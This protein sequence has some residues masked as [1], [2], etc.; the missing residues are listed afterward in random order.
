MLITIINADTLI[1]REF[2]NNTGSAAAVIGTLRF[3]SGALA[4]PTLAFFHDGSAL[5]FSVFILIGIIGIGLV[6]FK[7][8]NK[9]VTQET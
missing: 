7:P 1:L 3:G 2:K 8:L 6:H 4:G 9:Q 5:P